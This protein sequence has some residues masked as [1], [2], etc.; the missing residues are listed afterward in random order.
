MGTTSAILV[1]LG[2][3]VGIPALVG[4]GIAGMYLFSDRRGMRAER[5]QAK[6]KKPTT[7]PVHN[8]TSGE[9]K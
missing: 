2:I 5:A 9:Y 8:G 7:E 1:V 6:A 4:L 3:F